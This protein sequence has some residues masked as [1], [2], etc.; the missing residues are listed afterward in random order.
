MLYDGEIILF[1]DLRLLKD[2]LLRTFFSSN[3]KS[4]FVAQPQPY[5]CT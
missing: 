1:F 2:T 4:F 3:M 5:T